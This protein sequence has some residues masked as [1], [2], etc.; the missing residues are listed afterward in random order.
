MS[1]DTLYTADELEEGIEKALKAKDLESVRTLV[2]M[3]IGVDPDRAKVVYD[4]LL[5]GVS[6]ARSVPSQCDGGAK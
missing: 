4:T 6:L 5:L 2:H 3:L 1:K